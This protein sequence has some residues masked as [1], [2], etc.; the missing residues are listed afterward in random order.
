MTLL[1]D[2][3]EALRGK[4][5][6]HALIVGISEYPN[7]TNMPWLDLDPNNSSGA[8]TGYR[9]YQ[10]L[11]Q[12]Q[13]R[14]VAPLATCRLMISPSAEETKMEPRLQELAVSCNVD[15]FLR[16]ANEWRR[17]AQERE[18]NITFLYFAG[19]GFELSK[20]NPIIML[21]D[22][23][24]GIGPALRGGITVK[25]LFYGMG[26]TSEQPDIARTQLYFI[27]TDRVYP[28]RV[29]QSY[30]E[31]NTTAVFD[32]LPLG[33]DDRDAVIFYST[34]AGQATYAYVGEATF[35]S[36]A[37]LKCLEG[38]AAEPGETDQEGT[39]RWQVS[40]TSLMNG[41]NQVLPAL[42]QDSGLSG[43]DQLF[44]VGGQVRD[45]IICYL[46]A[47]PV[48]DLAIEVDPT[49]ALAVSHVEMSNEAGAVVFKHDAPLRPHPYRIQLP[50]GYYTLRI[51]IA[52]P[53]P[54][55]KDL[56]ARTR[57]LTPPRAVWKVKV[58]S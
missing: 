22:F 39:L 19:N 30:E 28:S 41:L 2:Q 10:W 21:Q 56:V 20:S 44:E 6:M 32:A 13:H 46:D 26:P 1:F 9:I 11:I 42:F 4:P 16:S 53:D 55:F 5:G 7:L 51:R 15:D 29:F 31:I 48:V 3:R 40:I 25:N 38:A 43:L 14:L 54:R 23:G 45:S 58:A 12:H 52:P 35:F 33:I 37:L 36:L 18:D 47:P 49:E 8:I 17:D 50:A 27:D 34:G 57:L 24:N